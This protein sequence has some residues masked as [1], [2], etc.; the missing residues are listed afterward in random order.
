MTYLFPDQVEKKNMELLD[1]WVIYGMN[2]T[3]TQKKHNLYFVAPPWAFMTAWIL[4]GMNFTNEKQYST[5][6]WFQLL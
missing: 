4:W 1:F 5:S 6:N 3:H 2:N